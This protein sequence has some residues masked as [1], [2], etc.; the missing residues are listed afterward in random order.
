MAPSVALKDVEHESTL[1]RSRGLLALALVGVLFGAL[2]L[3]LVQLQVVDHGH[4]RTLSHENRVKLVPV[5]PT[6]GLIYDR[7]GAVLALNVPT[8]SLEIVPE[9]VDDLQATLAELATLVDIAPEDERRFRRLLEERRR[10]ESIPIRTRLTQEEVA[11]FSVN[12]H[13]FPG[14]DVQARLTRDYPLGSLGVHLVGYVGRINEQELGRIDRANYRGTSHIGKTGVEQ[15]YEDVL[16]GRVGYEHV[17]TNAEGRALRV[18]K[19]EPPVSG[20]DLYLTLDARLQAAAEAAF[21]DEKGALVALDPA[22][23]EVLAFVSMPGYDPN[24]F[25][26]GI[27]PKS[28]G[29]LLSSPDRPLVNR[30]LHGR[31]PPGST[32]K[33]FIALAGLELGVEQ[34]RGSTWCPGWYRLKGEGRRYRDW[35]KWGHGEVDIDKAIVESC[36]VFFYQL[37]Y[38]LGIDRMHEFM[39]AFGFGR[40][41]GIDLAGEVSG[42]MP[43]REWKRGARGEP[44]YPGETLI[45][46]IGQGFTLVTPLQ[47]ASATA[48]LGMRGLRLRPKVALAVEHS[49]SRGAELLSPPQ[50]EALPQAEAAHWERIIEAM[51]G[52]VHGPRGTARAVGEGLDYRMAGK[53]GT[54]QVFSVGQNQ[55]YDEESI[56]K[57]LR[58]HALFV[59]FAP[60]DEP[61]VAVAVVVENG[62]SGSRAAAPIARKVVDYYMR[63][64]AEPGGGDK[65]LM[66]RGAATAPARATTGAR[67]M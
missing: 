49:A 35:K 22:S 4:F 65:L 36:D 41:T 24:A 8:F 29:E 57:A 7:N 16:H 60:A 39:T 55:E 63:N 50:A 17:E 10:F 13:R 28:Y 53:T 47:L 1:F 46:G 26:D 23:G 33:P 56:P 51:S 37:A 54:A 14:V 21:G 58:D 9:D 66:T 43:S 44:W 67:P 25:V 30:A 45:A 27:D 34:A 32:V 12:R 64:L 52:V 62:G 61:R 2:V 6:R 20:A 42:L 48:T 31:Y 3:R 5:A 15:A 18:L 40:E 19:R 38:A 11:R 59:A